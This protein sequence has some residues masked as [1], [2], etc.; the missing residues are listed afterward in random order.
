[1][2]MKCT[3]KNVELVSQIVLRNCEDENGHGEF[4]SET[5]LLTAFET[6][7]AWVEDE[8]GL[9]DEQLLKKDSGN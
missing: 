3:S 5:E 6:A 9:S 7:I 4:D 8:R 2:R 1:M